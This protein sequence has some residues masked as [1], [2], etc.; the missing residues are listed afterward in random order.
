MLRTLLPVVFL[1][2]V[3]LNLWVLLEMRHAETKRSYVTGIEEWRVSKLRHLLDPKTSPLRELEIFGGLRYYPVRPGYRILARFRPRPDTGI[4][5]RTNRKSKIRLTWVG[6]FEFM[7]SGKP[8]SLRAFVTP[9]DSAVS[10]NPDSITSKTN[11]TKQLTRSGAGAILLVPFR[12]ST[13]GRGTSRF[14]RYLDVT[15]ATDTSAWLDFNMAYN[16]YS[17]YNPWYISPRAPKANFLPVWIEA[18]E[19]TYKVVKEGK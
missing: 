8:C 13:N 2:L 4:A 19:R 11:K 1:L 6:Q 14:G 16:A 9:W 15:L 10:P 12:D 18:G 17:L 3:C 7:A 5:L